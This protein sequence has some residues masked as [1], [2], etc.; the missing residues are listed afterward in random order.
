[1]NRPTSLNALPSEI[2]ARILNGKSSWAAL[3]LWKTGDR[4]LMSKLRANGIQRME[5]RHVT[6][7][8]GLKTELVWP[9]CLK[10]FRLLSLS[11]KSLFNVHSV[12]VLRSELMRQNPGLETLS[13]QFPGAFPLI[14]E[15][16]LEAGATLPS[17]AILPSAQQGTDSTNNHAAKEGDIPLAGDFEEPLSKRPKIAS[18]SSEERL[19]DIWNPTKAFPS[20]KTLS[21]I[22][23]LRQ[24]TMLK[25]PTLPSVTQLIMRSSK[26]VDCSGLTS[27]ES[28]VILDRAETRHNLTL[29]TASKTLTSIDCDLYEYF[30]TSFFERCPNVT[31]VRSLQRPD[32]NTNVLPSAAENVV[33]YMMPIIV[34]PAWLGPKELTTEQ[35]KINTTLPLITLWTNLTALTVIDLDLLP[36]HFRLLPRGLKTLNF[37]SAGQPNFDSAR[38]HGA[39]SIAGPDAAMWSERKEALLKYGDT[40][41]GADKEFVKTYIDR[42]ENGSLLGLPVGL[43]SLI[44][45]GKDSKAW[46]TNRVFVLPPALLHFEARL[47]GHSQLLELLPPSLYELNLQVFDFLLPESLATHLTTMPFLHTIK[48]YAIKPLHASR[49]IPVLPRDMIDLSLEIK[50]ENLDISTMSSLPPHL[51]R[52]SILGESI[53]SKSAWLHLLPRKISYLKSYLLMDSSDLINLP[54]S[55]TELIGRIRDLSVRDT[56]SLP[57]SLSIID[58]YPQ[59]SFT[60]EKVHDKGILGKKGWIQILDVY[61]P[62]WRIF[63]KKEA[64][65][66]AELKAYNSSK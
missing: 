64:E 50:D 10:E 7:K 4:I 45:K 52:L 37:G 31:S 53:P 16:I 63:E 42:V 24:H 6:M 27:L 1:M 60:E 55:L 54:P 28:I 34:D 43:T 66:T 65:I 41:R 51:E 12:N 46:T 15:P 39:A 5:L 58:C 19:S 40:R 56:L 13:L 14:A 38:Q 25:L 17:S 30:N 62:F 26:P 59:R 61:R 2:L 57:K 8:T 23:T 22:D 9:R 35:L 21:L 3:E 44:I 18:D 48:L 11:V 49:L 20:L 36:D 33:L 32:R 29:D 47:H